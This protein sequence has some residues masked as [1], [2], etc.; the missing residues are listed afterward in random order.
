MTTT[1]STDGA[2]QNPLPIVVVGGGIAGLYSASELLRRG[3]SVTVLEMRH[4]F[5]GRIETGD[6]QTLDQRRGEAGTYFKA[7]FGPMRFE[8]AIQPK[9][10]DLCESL[11]VVFGPFTGPRS[12]ASP[13][14]YP[15]PPDEAGLA[16]LDLLR[17]GVYGMFGKQ[18]RRTVQD[19]IIL[20]DPDQHWL[21][22]LGDDNG[23]FDRVRKTARLKD[24][25][26]QPLLHT[27]GFWNALNSVLS[28]AAVT[29]IRDQ[30]PFFHLIPENPNAVEWG[31]FWLRLFK[32]GD[33]GELSTIP[34]GVRTIIE[35]LVSKLE[36]ESSGRISL[37]LNQEVVSISVANDP[38]LVTLEIHDKTSSSLQPY[39]LEAEHV[40]LALPQAPLLKL[41][42]SFPESVRAELG[43][44]NGFPLLKVFL[45]MSRPPWWTTIPAPQEYAWTLPTREIHYFLD[46]GKRHAMV[47][48]YTDRPGSEYW[49]T[50]LRDPD[51]HDRADIGDNPE[52]RAE[53]I[54][55]V[56]DQQRRLAA[57][58]P[59][60]TGAQ[61]PLRTPSDPVIQVLRDL[62]RDEPDLRDAV[63]KQLN[64]APWWLETAYRKPQETAADLWD[65]VGDYAIRDWSCDPF[66]AG[67]H[68]WRPRAQSWNVRAHLRAFALPRGAPELN[69][70][71]CG[72]AYSDYQGFIEGALR[73]A[74]DVVASIAG[75]PIPHSQD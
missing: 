38:R 8:L 61:E 50:L 6:L 4:E 52:L 67:C 7:E 30:G 47:L 71:I 66:G 32:L 75:E 24:R 74:A 18:P 10:E 42:A 54:R 31:I 68:A 55:L 45:V 17:V 33:S 39:S 5:G 62:L 59:G 13:I 40:I 16:S 48:V 2:S 29:K 60:E 72:E 1:S 51:H 53:L 65:S 69:I 46:E 70:H 34:E 36:H 73:S 57:Q 25:P 35:R 11:G 12:A 19:K 3:H 15:L 58:S 43:S 9:L 26:D 23:G 56:L 22:D 27:L 14:D 21:D 64:A 49:R 20:T 28:N 44:V 41:S 37:L 63:A